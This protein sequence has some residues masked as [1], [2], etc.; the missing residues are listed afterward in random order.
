MVCLPMLSALVRGGVRLGSL[1]SAL[2]ALAGCG[3]TGLDWVAEARLDSAE[4]QSNAS[5]TANSRWTGPALIPATVELQA[6]LEL[7]PRLN[8]T[9]T[10]GE[11]DVAPPASA[12]DRALPGVVV[13]VNNYN[14]TNGSTPAYGYGYGYIAAS[15]AARGGSVP[16]LG[17]TGSRSAG[18]GLAPG[19]NWPAVS[20][21]G[22]S[23]PYHT[24][25]ASPWGRSQ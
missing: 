14:S 18:S 6:T 21:A 10:L 11:L 16:D 5:G 13:T 3:A 12:A 15:R 22:P 17:S 9:I 1:L 23:F 8:R 24:A 25:P 20:A 19:Q 2:C 7:R 4:P